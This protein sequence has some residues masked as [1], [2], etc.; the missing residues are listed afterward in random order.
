VAPA[1]LCC[2]RAEGEAIALGIDDGHEPGSTTLG[3]FGASAPTRGPDLGERGVEVGDVEP[4][5]ALALLAA[6][7]AVQSDRRPTPAQLA[8]VRRLELSPTASR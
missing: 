5:R 3:A 6:A 8:P 4:Q 1:G 2:V 7:T